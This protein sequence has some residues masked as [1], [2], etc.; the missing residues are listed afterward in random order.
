M[1]ELDFD[2]V[3]WAA[4]RHSEGAASDVPGLLRRIVD[5]EEPAE[6]VT[7]LSERICPQGVAVGAATPGVIPFLVRISLIDGL[8]ARLDVL[9]LLR[10]IS[11]AS[12]AWRA[13]ANNALPQ[14]RANYVEKIAW[15]EA[16][17]ESFARSLPELARLVNDEDHELAGLVRDLVSAHDVELPD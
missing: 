8:P 9:R 17:D 14:F 1:R 15:E 12:H 7:G 5:D 2:A 10:K 4:L 11:D 16:V 13:S 6:A 3:D